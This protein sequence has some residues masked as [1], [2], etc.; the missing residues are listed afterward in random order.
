HAHRSV[1][2]PSA[3]GH[4]PMHAEGKET[5]EEVR[6]AGDAAERLSSV[7]DEGRAQAEGEI[8]EAGRRGKGR[9]DAGEGEGQQDAESEELPHRPHVARCPAA[10]AP[11]SGKGGGGRRARRVAPGLPRPFT[12]TANAGY[13]G[14]VSASGPPPAALA[15]RTSSWFRHSPFDLP[16]PPSSP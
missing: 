4:A 5:E 9:G 15:R 11:S 8:A 16:L 3:L 1:E 2:I 14:A 13:A 7:D 10:C 6:L 12:C